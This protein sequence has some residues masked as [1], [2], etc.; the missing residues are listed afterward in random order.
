[1]LVEEESENKQSG[2]KFHFEWS[3]LNVFDSVLRWSCN[4]L[5]PSA[6]MAKPAPAA[7]QPRLETLASAAFEQINSTNFS[8]QSRCSPFALL[9]DTFWLSFCVFWGLSHADCRSVRDKDTALCHWKLSTFQFINFVS[10]KPVHF[11]VYRFLLLFLRG[12]GGGE[13]GA[14]RMDK[15]AMEEM[16]G[17]KWCNS[18]VLLFVTFH[19]SSWLTIAP[20]GVIA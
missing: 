11:S 14:A 4:L 10:L 19:D 7:T 6:Q 15:R 13:E 8:L 9:S 3:F 5:L 17:T 2:Q 1:M 12:L 16:G 18:P 20:T